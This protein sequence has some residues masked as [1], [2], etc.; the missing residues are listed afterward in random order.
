LWKI[1]WDDAARK[2]LRKLDYTVQEQILSYLEKR[3]ATEED[4]RRFGEGLSADKVGLWRYRVGNYRIICQIEDKK[5]VVLVVR[6]GH[7]RDVYDN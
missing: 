4:P 7:R 1:E 6:V 2:E 5:L 3:I